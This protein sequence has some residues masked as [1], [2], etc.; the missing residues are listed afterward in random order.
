M[1][2]FV[3]SLLVLVVGCNYAKPDYNYNI[4][5]FYKKDAVKDSAYSYFIKINDFK[6]N[7]VDKKG[8]SIFY[9]IFKGIY[10]SNPYNILVFNTS[11]GVDELTA[12]NNSKMLGIIIYRNPKCFSFT[13]SIN[14]E[15]CIDKRN[16]VIIGEL[17]R[18]LV[19]PH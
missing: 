19:D 7:D 15:D 2:N 3:I 6:F 8:D 9:G 18:V 14:V 11:I 16:P 10:K 4:C 17:H 12:I 5:N 1:K 13:S